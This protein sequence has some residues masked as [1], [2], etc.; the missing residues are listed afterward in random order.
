MA[1]SSVMSN[2]EE[3]AVAC[4]AFQGDEG[5][6]NKL[7]KA[8]L[9]FVFTVAKMY[10]QDPE[11]FN[12]LVSAG[13]I[14]LIDAAK[15]FDPHRGFRF[16]SYAVWNIRKEM[17]EYLAKN[18]RIIRIP[19]S[20]NSIVAKAKEAQIVIYSREGREATEE[21]MLEYIKDNLKNTEKLNVKDL[22]DSLTADKRAQSLDQ[23]LS[24]HGESPSTLLDVY[25]GTAGDEDHI[26][27]RENFQHAIKALMSSLTPRETEVVEIIHG[28][29]DNSS[30]GTFTEV[31]YRWGVG[32]QAVKVV[33]A[34][35]IKR[36]RM[37]ARDLK[38]D[39][40]DIF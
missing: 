12:D 34:R 10:S 15:K 6:R 1:K 30:P 28:L 11:T 31:S 32:V 16:I 39:I 13:N 33:Y 37:K 2:D 36:M 29:G 18:T 25:D 24:E 35:A 26:Y 3:Y 17:L 5:A 21:E 9:R 27:D 19:M 22:A 8:N 23:P 14:G 7:V 4:M 40:S 38:I 20:R